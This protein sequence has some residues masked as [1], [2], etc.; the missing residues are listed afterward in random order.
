MREYL[1]FVQ[2]EHGDIVWE[3][4]YSDIDEMLQ[5]VKT[6]EKPSLFGVNCFRIVIQT[7]RAQRA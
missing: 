1:V 7:Q 4:T 5:D 3:N 6:L 2:G